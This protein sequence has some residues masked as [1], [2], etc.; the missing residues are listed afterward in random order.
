[1]NSQSIHDPNINTRNKTPKKF[2]LRAFSRFQAFWLH[3]LV[4]TVIFCILLAITLLIWYPGSLIYAGGIHGIKI[5]AS[6]DLVLGPLL[7]LLLFS[8][9]K[10]SLYFDLCVI[11]IIQIGALSYGVFALEKERPQA[12]IL[13]DDALHI[14][15]QA[16]FEHYDDK[17]DLSLIPGARDGRIHYLDLPLDPTEAV[18]ASISSAFISGLPMVYRTDLYL[19]SASNDLLNVYKQ[20]NKWHSDQPC[21][22]VPVSSKH[23][24]KAHTACINTITH[25]FT[26]QLSSKTKPS[27]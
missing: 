6:V 26:M 19:K 13:A 24:L 1:M 11:A 10:K 21:L 14:L 18:S 23:L 20:L 12:V 7:T 5:I 22:M 3:M 15:T 25:R 16:D 8:P 2:N 9:Q 27:Q 4:S 17:I